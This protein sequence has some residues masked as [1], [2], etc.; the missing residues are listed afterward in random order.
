[1]PG[2]SIG[3][4]IYRGYKSMTVEAF[5]MEREVGGLEGGGGGFIE[6]CYSPWP[7]IYS[8]R[9]FETLDTCARLLHGY[10][11]SG[12]DQIQKWVIEK[13]A[14][15]WKCVFGA[16]KDGRTNATEVLRLIYINYD[17]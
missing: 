5:I 17:A 8:H 16:Y 4:G 13:S 10:I 12:I 1:M 7:N 3:L 9:L 15:V 14:G 2:L 6:G 11:L